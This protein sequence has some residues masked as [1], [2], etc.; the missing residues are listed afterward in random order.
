M[1]ASERPFLMW[2]MPLWLRHWI[3]Y[4][5]YR[6]HATTRLGLFE[7]APL[8]LAPAVR[9]SLL[10]TDVAHQPMAWDGVYELQL[11]RRMANLATSV[12]TTGTSRV[13]GPRRRQRIASLPSRLRRATSPACATT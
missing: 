12:R 5:V 6:R 4:R 2:H 7:D 3:F 9:L 13:Y 8:A 11:S 10:P 1:T